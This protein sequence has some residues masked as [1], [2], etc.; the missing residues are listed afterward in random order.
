MCGFVVFQIFWPLCNVSILGKYDLR[1]NRIGIV[2]GPESVIF[3]SDRINGRIW[4]E[5]HLILDFVVLGL[6]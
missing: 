5:V 4:I 6:V 2:T 3:R 1:S